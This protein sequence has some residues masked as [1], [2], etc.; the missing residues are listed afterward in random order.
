MV[1]R[2]IDACYRRGFGLILGALLGMVYGLVSQTIN[3]LVLPGVPLYQPPFGL[4]GN[5]AWMAVLGAVLGVLASWPQSSVRGILAASGL[6]AGLLML[7]SFAGVSFT[8]RNR[9]GL[10]IAALFLLLPFIAMIAPV[11]GVVRW[12]VNREMDARRDGMRPGRRALGPLAALVAAGLVGALVLYHEET[13]VE[14]AAMHSLMQAG[15]HASSPT[16][17]PPAL[18]AEDVGDF[19]RSAKGSYTLEWTRENLNRFRIPRPGRNFDSHAA[20]LARFADG[21]QLACLFVAPD[22]PPTCK[23]LS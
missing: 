6:A 23:G 5:I 20:V 15:L 13:R 1:N 18:Q 17:L 2:Q 10:V 14:L 7:V 21:W 16:E 9:G 3:R 4:A 22:E 11:I 19:L 12:L 8:E